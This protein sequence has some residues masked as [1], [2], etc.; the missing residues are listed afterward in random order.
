MNSETSPRWADR[1]GT[2]TRT[3]LIVVASIF[4]MI[5]VGMVAG[6]GYAVFEDGKVPTKPIV[7]LIFAAMIALVISI[8]WALRS[9]FRSIYPGQMSNFDRRYWTMWKVVLVICAVLGLGLAAFG[10]TDQSDGFSLM[11]SNAPI[12]PLTAIIV[13]IVGAILAIA[14]VVI[15]FRAIDDH[16]ANAYLWGSNVA[17]HFLALAF[18][19]YWLLA[20][21]GL[22]PT[23]TIG[24]A[25]SIVL[26]SCIVQGVVWALFKFR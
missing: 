11:A 25:L 17:F 13:S 5:S 10:I 1:L 24:I 22:V 7:W 4:G 21:G 14:S 23:L 16:E 9:L 8:V 12:T 20:R 2:G 26:V 19:I 6:V 15:Y 18:P 3:I